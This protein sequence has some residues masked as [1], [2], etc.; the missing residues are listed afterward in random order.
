MERFS[1]SLRFAILILLCWELEIAAAVNDEG[2]V[3]L[4]FKEKLVSPFRDM[5]DWN[6]E[7]ASD[8]CSWFAAECAGGR[9]VSLIANNGVTRKLLQVGR[10]G[11]NQHLNNDRTQKSPS[12]PSS[13]PFSQTSIHQSRPSW[14]P[15]TSPS[16]NLPI[17]LPPF[18]SNDVPA[19]QPSPS[20]T[21]F[22]TPVHSPSPTSETPSLTPSFSLNPTILSSHPSLSLPPSTISPSSV[23]ETNQRKHSISRTIYISTIGG[24]SF[25]VALIIFLVF[26]YRAN[27]VVTVRPWSTGL[28]GQLQKA[29]VTGVP[30][31]KRS[32][33]EIACEDF[34]N[35]IGSLPDC[36]LYKGT[37]SSG[38]E[39]AVASTLI[40]SSKDWSKQCE[41]QFRMK[42][43]SLSKV[44]H[45]N[46]VN[47]LGY[48]E[49]QEPFTRMMV[50]EYAPNGTLF[51]HLHV[52]EAEHLDWTTRLRI[53]MGIAYCLDYMHQL[54]PPMIM[55]NLDSSSIYL[56]ED[57]AAKVS[58]I[59]FWVESEEIKSPPSNSSGTLQ[60]PLLEP[61]NTVYA[62]GLLLLEILSG[63][64]P[65]SRDVLLENWASCYLNGERPINEMIDPTLTLFREED[66][67]ALCK[68]IKSC[69][70]PDLQ[71]RPTMSKIVSSLKDITLMTPDRAVPM[72]SPLWWAELEILTSEAN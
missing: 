27:K 17:F 58:D 28:S 10:K 4:R 25:L 6:G 49:E 41:S 57:Y 2:R 56:T 45:K 59:R 15:L 62:F 14:S 37:L 19:S 53:A 11:K 26:C 20:P 30:T 70:N 40:T 31:L 36:K 1:W 18:P 12:S 42:I 24:V 13:F 47:L 44:N 54:S 29:F 39:I 8:P 35:I 67:I 50:F 46:F 48:C 72:A 38:V 9:A 65:A 33:I 3:L 5:A 7:G 63:R 69:I 32:E 66:V 68:V 34:S 64:F 23:R 16:A 43:S 22:M 61:K 71:E 21:D 60:V 52:K 55:T 51:E